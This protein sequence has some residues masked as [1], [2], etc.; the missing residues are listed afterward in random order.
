M[1]QFLLSKLSRTF[2][3]LA[4]VGRKEG[5]GEEANGLKKAGGRQ[6][7]GPGQAERASGGYCVLLIRWITVQL[8]LRGTILGSAL[9]RC[10]ALYACCGGV[11][12]LAGHGL[13][14]FFNGL[15]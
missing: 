11:I 6:N 5:L 14:A 3:P 8:Q 4:G 2:S 13:A 15:K 10:A 1:H 12:D 9:E 7:Q